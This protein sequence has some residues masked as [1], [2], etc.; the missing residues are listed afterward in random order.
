MSVLEFGWNYFT[1]AGEGNQ[2]GWCNRSFSRHISPLIM[3]RLTRKVGLTIGCSCAIRW[4]VWSS[5]R[6]L[7]NPSR[8]DICQCV[9]GAIFHQKTLYWDN[10]V[11]DVFKLLC[12]KTDV[13]A[14]SQN[15]SERHWCSCS[16]FT[17]WFVNCNFEGLEQVTE[18]IN[19][20]RRSLLRAPNKNQ[21]QPSSHPFWGDEAYP[22]CRRGTP[23]TDSQ[24]VAELTHRNRQHSHTHRQFRVTH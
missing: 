9:L 16:G 11:S 5:V 18:T 19:T 10:V 6:Y 13:L 4:M 12:L 8:V 21:S 3:L 15:V 22:C 23:W 24:S 1:R 17:R 7:K 2:E 20:S 14:K